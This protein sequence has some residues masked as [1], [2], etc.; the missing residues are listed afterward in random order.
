MRNVFNKIIRRAT[1]KQSLTQMTKQL[2][3][4]F[5][6]PITLSYA[7]VKLTWFDQQQ[8]SEALW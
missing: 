2:L 5:S 3:A 4:Y 1:E 6:K 7:F 8:I